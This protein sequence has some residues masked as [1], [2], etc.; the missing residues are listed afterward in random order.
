MK[1]LVCPK[2]YVGTKVELN[3]AWLDV[4]ID[5]VT[6]EERGYT[7]VDDVIARILLERPGY[8]AVSESTYPRSI[9]A[10]K[11]MVGKELLSIGI[12]TGQ[13]IVPVAVEDL[14]AETQRH[15]KTGQEYQER[16]THPRTKTW[17]QRLTQIFRR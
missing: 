1:L 11:G 16:Q 13:P 4:Y 7:I 2:G 10:L 15:I 12:M 9:E 6:P 17:V 3:G 5:M 14:P 8:E